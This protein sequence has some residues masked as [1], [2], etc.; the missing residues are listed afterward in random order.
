MAGVSDA[1]P[2][3]ADEAAAVPESVIAADSAEAARVALL[4]KRQHEDEE[5]DEA[6]VE[7]F[8]CSDPPATWAG[9]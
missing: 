6:L 2:V 9:L 3:I 4:R 5:L 7:S 1:E 8:P